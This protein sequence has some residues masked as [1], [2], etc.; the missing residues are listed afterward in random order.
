MIDSGQS[1]LALL[2][3]EYANKSARSSLATQ[4]LYHGPVGRRAG[5]T[6]RLF[7][8]ATGKVGLAD[9]FR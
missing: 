3:N 4:L 6:G 7:R 2:R 8:N 5:T 1:F 9:G